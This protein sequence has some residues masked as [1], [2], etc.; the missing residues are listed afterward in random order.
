MVPSRL[1]RRTPGNC[2][3]TTD[4]YL[5]ITKDAAEKIE[6]APIAAGEIGM[7]YNA[8][9]NIYIVDK[10]EFHRQARVAIAVPP[11]YSVLRA[12]ATGPVGQWM[13]QPSSEIN[14]VHLNLLLRP[15]T[16]IPFEEF[17]TL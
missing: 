14:Q 9:D 6:K 16:I 1:A 4:P 12:G 15:G 2:M 11:E 10:V 3:R 13:R 8:A 5:V 7:R 17:R